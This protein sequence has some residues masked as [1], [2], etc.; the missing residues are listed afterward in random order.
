M[1]F[2]VKALIGFRIVESLASTHHIPMGA[3]REVNF[4]ITGPATQFLYF[5]CDYPQLF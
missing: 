2:T 4:V 5:S 1:I 3:Y